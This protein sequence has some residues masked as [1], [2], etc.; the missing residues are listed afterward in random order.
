MADP[1]GD[2]LSTAWQRQNVDFSDAGRFN[3]GLVIMQEASHC[4]K[5]FY[6]LKFLRGPK[7]QQLSACVLIE[8]D[9]LGGH[10]SLVP[11]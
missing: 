8:A 1:D 5:L 7:C 9:F 10:V 6:L 2:C 4:G 3:V 11:P